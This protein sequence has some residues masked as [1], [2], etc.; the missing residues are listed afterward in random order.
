MSDKLKKGH[1]R[2]AIILM[3]RCHFEER[4]KEK[5]LRWE[6]KNFLASL[7]SD[8]RCHSFQ[9]GRMPEGILAMT[10]RTR[11]NIQKGNLQTA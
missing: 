1:V 7:R 9:Y 11:R 5:V 2:Q 8:D 10:Y 4:S 3:P 6:T